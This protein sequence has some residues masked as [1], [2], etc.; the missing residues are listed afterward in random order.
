MPEQDVLLF[1]VDQTQTPSLWKAQRAF[2]SAEV[3]RERAHWDCAANR[4][5][6]AAAQIAFHYMRY[7]T[8][9]GRYSNGRYWKKGEI[10]SEYVQRHDSRA[11]SALQRSLAART[12]GDYSP[13]A[14]TPKDI[15]GFFRLV[16]EMI[17]RAF[18]REN[19]P[20][21]TP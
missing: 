12:R 5:Y 19:I 15:E 3:L 17:V 11:L 7:T 14:V 16:A 10:E 18:Q 9:N 4:Y 6:Y 8:P 20:R 2:K 1:R 21:V 13:L